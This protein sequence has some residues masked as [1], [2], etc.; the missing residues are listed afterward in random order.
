MERTKRGGVKRKWGLKIDAGIQ[1]GRKRR[2]KIE[3]GEFIAWGEKKKEEKEKK[4]ES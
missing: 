1:L 2:R 3:N 4:K